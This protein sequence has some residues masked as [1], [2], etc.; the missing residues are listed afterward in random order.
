[1]N[2]KFFGLI[3]TG[4]LL[5]FFTAEAQNTNYPIKKVKGIDYYIYT[6]QPSE[7]LLAIGRRFEMSA[8]EISKANPEIKDGLK[9]GQELLIPISKKSTQ[10]NSGNF[11]QHK[12]EKKQT[13]FAISRKYKV[14]QEDIEKFNLDVKNGLHEGMILNI[15]D[16]DKIKKQKEAERK[17]LTSTSNSK[18]TLHEVQESETLFSISKQ[19][20]VDIKEIIKLNP[21]ADKKIAVG[22]ELKIPAKQVLTKSPPQ[23][24]EIVE[25]NVK[26]IKETS[27]PVLAP[28]N[29]NKNIRIAFLLPFM[30]DQ[31]K[32]ETVLERFQNFYAGA[33]LAIQAAKEKG[34]SF[35]IYTFDTDKTEEKINEV[36]NNPE[37]KTMDLII[38]PAFS[39]QVPLVAGF[40]KENKVYTLIP[41]TAKVSD[42][43]NN[44]FLI[45]FNPGSDAELKFLSE[46]LNGKLRN[47]HV[48]FAEIQ[49]INPLD[50]G[51]IREEALKSQLTKNRKSFGTIELSSPENINFGVDFKKGEK[52]LVI[53]NSD[54]FS[55]VSPYIS[56]LLTASSE[57][58]IVLLEQYSWRNQLEKKP[59]CITISPFIPVMNDAAVTDFNVQIDRYYGKDI[60]DE[61][62]RYDLLGY[63][64]T[65]YFIKY[66]NRFGDKFGSKIGAIN[67]I[68]GIQSQPLFERISNESGYI[69]QRVYLEEIKAR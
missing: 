33:L 39:N 59:D 41:F 28:S 55:N 57:F 19:Y 31:V 58:N 6:V 67:S 60:T 46:Q 45:Q 52:N 16:S 36:L 7:G 18:F 20:G 47:M 11:I 43:E 35:E 42:I 9:V 51:R 66:I 24:K 48:V 69:N 63:D 15:P 17:L 25:N 27:K 61:T 34:I 53:F 50:D 32:K 1:M 38:G 3:L 68:P 30:L 12:V 40:A 26:P 23:H 2:K 37:L 54:K 62:P 21:G 22:S 56:S 29:E 13:L 14:S 64:L 44:P 8:D 65:N 49:G 5:L 4:L 10:K